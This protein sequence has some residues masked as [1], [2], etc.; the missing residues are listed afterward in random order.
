MFFLAKY[1]I[2]QKLHGVTQPAIAYKK[3]DALPLVLLGKLH[4]VNSLCLRGHISVL[5]SKAHSRQI[6]A[7]CT[8]QGNT[9][10]GHLSWRNKLKTSHHQSKSLYPGF[11]SQ[12]ALGREEFR[13]RDP[14]GSLILPDARMEAWCEGEGETLLWCFP[15]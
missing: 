3:N 8:A 5:L 15:Q 9:V 10:R 13:A 7:M 14:V 11:G 1:K 4:C 12:N 2:P 6:C